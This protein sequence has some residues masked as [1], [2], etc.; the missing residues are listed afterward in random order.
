ML[1]APLDGLMANLYLVAHVGGRL[2]MYARM[3]FL[4][5]E[6]LGGKN[7]ELVSHTTVVEFLPNASI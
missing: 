1:Y 2:F 5:T 6:E 3:L 4:F 7:K